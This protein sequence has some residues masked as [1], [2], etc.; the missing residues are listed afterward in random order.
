MRILMKVAHLGEIA[1]MQG[2]AAAGQSPGQ[3]AEQPGLTSRTVLT[4]CV[5]LSIYFSCKLIFLLLVY[6][7][8]SCTFFKKGYF[9]NIVNTSDIIF[10]NFF[11]TST[12]SK[13]Q[14]KCVNH[15]ISNHKLYVFGVFVH[16]IGIPSPFHMYLLT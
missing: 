7:H 11:Y 12:L 16:F 6:T 9:N 10:F 8:V 1:F 5:N 15:D 14:K 3:R 2:M 4:S 13:F